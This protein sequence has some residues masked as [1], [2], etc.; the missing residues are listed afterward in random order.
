MS[1]VLEKTIYAVEILFIKFREILTILQDF[2]SKSENFEIL[3][4][5][6]FRNFKISKFLYIFRD[7][8]IIEIFIS[9]FKLKYFEIFSSKFKKNIR[10]PELIEIPN[11]AKNHILDVK[12]FGP[13][14][15]SGTPYQKK[16]RKYQVPN[17]GSC[18]IN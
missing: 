8:Q 1:H 13:H 14:L 5:L 2:V 4:F 10:N 18:G 15:V 9:R 3:V 17:K 11:T 16:L 12:I 7:S 6:I